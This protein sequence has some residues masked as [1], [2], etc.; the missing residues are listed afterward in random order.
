ME[1]KTKK[2]EEE[3]S[4]DSE[5]LAEDIL[6]LGITEAV[7]IWSIGIIMFEMLES[8]N[9]IKLTFPLFKT[10]KIFILFFVYLG[11]SAIY[12]SRCRYKAMC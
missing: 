3:N 5:Q 11:F 1:E 7:D 12:I 6:T 4:E 10:S 2:L 8:C 9:T